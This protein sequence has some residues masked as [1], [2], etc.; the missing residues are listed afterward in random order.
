MFKNPCVRCNQSLVGQP[1]EN[2]HLELPGMYV[3][4]VVCKCGARHG[5]FIAAMQD[6]PGPDWQA[7]VD[8]YIGKTHIGEEHV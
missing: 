5:D 4:S 7:K 2:Q 8:R 1:I 3:V 6:P